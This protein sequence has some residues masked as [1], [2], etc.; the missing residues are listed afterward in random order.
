[1]PGA[2][3]DADR[4]MIRRIVGE[5]NHAWRNGNT[6]ELD[7]YFHADMVIV[8]PGYQEL[9]RGRETCVRSYADFLGSARIHETSETERAIDVWGDTA[10]ASYGW[11]MTYEQ[12]GQLA[13]ETGHDQFVFT[14]EPDGWRAVWRTVTFT[15]SPS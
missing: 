1:M 6:V 4:R 8:G 3:A 14:R 2:D 12:N 10:V 13:R 7:R 11:T 5:M 15:P 9:T